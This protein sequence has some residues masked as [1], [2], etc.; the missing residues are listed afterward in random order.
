MIH[1]NKHTLTHID[2]IDDFLEPE[3]C[4]LLI[5]HI[6]DTCVEDENVSNPTT[7]VSCKSATLDGNNY[8]IK[9]IIDVVKTNLN[10]KILNKSRL[11]VIKYI[12]ELCIRKIHGK[13]RLHCDGPGGDMDKSHSY[14][15]D[16]LRVLTLIIALNSDYDGGEFIFPDQNVIVKLKKGQAITFPPYWTHP[17]LVTSPENGTFRYTINTWIHGKE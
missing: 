3:L 14:K 9:Q 1:P 10:E 4:D 11:S 5:K 7:N 2:V 6:D 16:E 8:K 13:T 17:H 12:D 15:S